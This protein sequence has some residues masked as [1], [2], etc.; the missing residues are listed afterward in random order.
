MHT[1]F[2]FI[3]HTVPASMKPESAPHRELSSLLTT[4]PNLVRKQ[5]EQEFGSKTEPARAL[6]GD[7]TR[8]RRVCEVG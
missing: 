3:K 6:A 8:L 7:L 5:R 1:N 2:G 4:Q